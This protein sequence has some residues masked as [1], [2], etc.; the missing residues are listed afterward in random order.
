MIRFAQFDRYSPSA[1]LD[2]ARLKDH[3]WHDGS[4]GLSTLEHLE[5]NLKAPW[6]AAWKNMHVFER[7]T[8]QSALV[9]AVAAH[10]LDVVHGVFGK[11]NIIQFLS[12]NLPVEGHADLFVGA[13]IYSV[14][15]EF[16]KKKQK[17]KQR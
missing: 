3:I 4:V 5:D 11:V 9:S 10:V 15:L 7:N 8:A 13:G 17:K 16:A 2:V 12:K 1:G 6:E 14:P